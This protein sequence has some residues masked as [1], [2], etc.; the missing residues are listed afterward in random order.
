MVKSYSQRS[1]RRRISGVYRHGAARRIQRAWRGRRVT[2]KRIKRTVVAMKPTKF[3]MFKNEQ[4]DVTNTLTTILEPSQVL[5]TSTEADAHYKREGYKIKAMGLYLQGEILVDSS[6][7]FTKCR[8]LL[9]RGY[10]AGA[11][12]LADV[13]LTQ[14]G[15]TYTDEYLQ[16]TNPKNCK[17]LWDRTFSCENST[18][19]IPGRAY[20]IVHVDKF[21]KLNETWRYPSADPAFSPE[22]INPGSYMLIAISNQTAGNGPKVDMN[23]RLSFKDLQ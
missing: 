9:V 5:F 1:K 22:P 21:W 15:F 3:T 10:R 6:A 12:T 8:L 2:T 19:A 18:A 7:R 16:F 23:M 17:V 11:L 13:G 4:L 20:P 14:P